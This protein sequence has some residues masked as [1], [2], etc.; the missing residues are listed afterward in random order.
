M[1]A[2]RRRLPPRRMLSLSPAPW[3]GRPTE[4]LTEWTARYALIALLVAE[5]GANGI[6]LVLRYSSGAE[7]PHGVRVVVLDTALLATLIPLYLAGS[8]GLRNLGL[9]RV[10]GARS[11]GLALLAL[12]VVGL[13]D[14]A[15]GW[16]VNLAPLA[17]PNSG[18]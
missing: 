12:L 8:L 11:V 3:S 10:P 14:L 9:R 16:A 17:N 5:L 13:C 7:V 2:A 1:R 15:W 4:R 6:V 18:I